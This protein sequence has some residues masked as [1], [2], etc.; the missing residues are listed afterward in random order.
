MDTSVLDFAELIAK[1]FRGCFSREVAWSW[2][3]MLLIGFLLRSDKLGMTTTK[4]TGDR[5]QIASLVPNLV[6]N[7]EIDDVATH[8]GWTAWT[9]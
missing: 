8:A 6:E 3:T 9:A 7:W 4:P 1:R 5:S 2:F